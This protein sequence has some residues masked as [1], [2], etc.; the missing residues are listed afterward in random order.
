MDKPF[1]KIGNIHINLNTI[2][3]IGKEKDGTLKVVTTLRRK[4]GGMYSFI[5]RDRNQ[6]K[7]LMLELGQ[8][9]TGE[10]VDADVSPGQE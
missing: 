4:D 1:I 10:W 3:I 5:V 2:A 9:T 7:G 8:F 6:S